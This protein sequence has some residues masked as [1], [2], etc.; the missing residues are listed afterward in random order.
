M[1]INV[2]KQSGMSLIELMIASTLSLILLVGVV[3]IF[4]STKT[5]YVTTENISRAQENGR[6]ALD[7]LSRYT[8]M[9]GYWDYTMLDA[10]PDPFESRCDTPGDPCSQDGTGNN[11]SDRLAIQY[12]SPDDIDCN[13]NPTTANSVSKNIFWIEKD[14]EGVSS[15]YCHGYDNAKDEWLGS[16]RPYI[17]GVDSMQILYGIQDSSGSVTQFVNTGRMNNYKDDNADGDINDP[18]EFEWFNVR[19][20]KMALLAQ[21]GLSDDGTFKERTYVL[22]DSDPLKFDDGQSRYVFSTTFLIPNVEELSP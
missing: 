21:S 1:N 11:N 3:Q 18:G 22:L 14:A 16:A 6:F 17:S 10:T 8:R 13:G 7:V 9:A 5:A 15:L 12:F 20:I 19:A 2:D 4:V